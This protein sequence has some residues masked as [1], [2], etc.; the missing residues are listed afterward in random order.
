MSNKDDIAKLKEILKKTDVIESCTNERSETKWRFFKLT[1]V[2]IFASLLRDVPMRYKDAVLTQ[3]L[4]KNNTVSCPT[5]EKNTKKPYKD[6]LCHL[7]ALALQLHENDKR[8]EEETSKLFNLFLINSTKYDP[9]K[10]QGVCMDDILSVEDLVGINIFIY[11][12]NL[13]D[14]AMVG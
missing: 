2:T 4:L 13:I 1:N 8:I 3:P 5:Y 14:G 7:R 12:I 10:L 9:S 11:D 6:N